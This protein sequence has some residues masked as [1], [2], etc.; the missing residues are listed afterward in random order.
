M[1][2]LD[3]NTPKFAREEK[4]WNFRI[5]KEIEESIEKWRHWWKPGRYP[6]GFAAGGDY[7]G[8]WEENEKGGTG[9]ACSS[10]RGEKRWSGGGSSLPATVMG[11]VGT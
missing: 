2:V 7:C 4:P 1:T 6:T 10:M 11:S 3:W 8:W 5:A 9:A